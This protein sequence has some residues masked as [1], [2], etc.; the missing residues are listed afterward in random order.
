MAPRVPGPRGRRVPLRG[1]IGETFR[2]AG[3]HRGLLPRDEAPGARDGYRRTVGPERDMP[4]PVDVRR[5]SAYSAYPAYPGSGP[6][7]PPRPPLT[8]RMRP[9][10]W[11]ALDC[12]VAG[13][14]ALC[15]AASGAK[16]LPAGPK[17]PVV[18]LFMAAIF[19]PVAL[20]RKAPVAWFGSLVI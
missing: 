4:Y 3:Q 14:A 2:R 5:P 8:K 17:L 16:S 7:R 12:V 11:I 19:I 1:D 9:G 18:L 15:A 20:R 10:H 6:S 13:F